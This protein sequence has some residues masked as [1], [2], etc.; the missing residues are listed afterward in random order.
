MD[1]DDVPRVGSRSDMTKMTELEAAAGAAA[2][3]A[4]TW[5]QHPANQT[6]LQQRAR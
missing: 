4:S 3:T 6:Q 1:G 5:Q 2:A